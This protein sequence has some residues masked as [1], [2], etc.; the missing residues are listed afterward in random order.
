MGPPVQPVFTSHT[1]TSDPSSLRASMS[2]YTRGRMGMK[3][4]PKHGLKVATGSTI[5]LSV[6]ATLAV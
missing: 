5:P 1:L 4:A 3:G 2:A 6:P